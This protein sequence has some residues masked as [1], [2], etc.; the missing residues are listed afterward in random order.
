MRVNDDFGDWNVKKQFDDDNSVLSNWKSMLQLRKKEKGV[1]VYGHFEMVPVEEG[2]ENVF[3]YTMADTTGQRKALV[4]LKFSDKEQVFAA[5]GFEDW[6]QLIGENRNVQISKQGL[7]LKPYE[8]AIYC[9]W[10]P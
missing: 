10:S 5:T 2:G 7:E 3:A 8:G 1:F 4:S 9:N 6:R